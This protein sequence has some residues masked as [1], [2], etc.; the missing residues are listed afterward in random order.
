MTGA[1]FPASTAG[2]FAGF[3]ALL[4]Q[5]TFKPVDVSPH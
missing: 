3:A 1:L 4:S 5:F 2:S